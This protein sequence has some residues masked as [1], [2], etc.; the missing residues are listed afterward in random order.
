MTTFVAFLGCLGE[1][2]LIYAV[3]IL[4]Q[5]SKKLGEVTKMKPY[6]RGYHVSAALIFLA[7]I[8][9]VLNASLLFSPMA[10]AEVWRQEQ[11]IALSLPHNVLL[12]IGL[13]I[14]LSITIRYWSWL[15][16]E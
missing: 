9:R 12:A 3:V 8:I 11:W 7:L 13:T 16:K 14:A 5:L 15:L 2:A 4:L 10:N 1:A 6:Y